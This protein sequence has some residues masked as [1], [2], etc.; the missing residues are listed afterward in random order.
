MK[1]LINTLLLAG[2][3]TTGLSQANND[4]ENLNIYS[5]RIGDGK[6]QSTTRFDCSDSIYVF[7][8]SETPRDHRSTVEARWFNP[9]GDLVKSGERGFEP[10]NGG[11]QYAWDGVDIEAGGDAFSNLLGSMFDPAAGY[12]DA[13]GQWRVDLQV[14]GY[15]MPSVHVEV[16]C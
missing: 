14:D 3:C 2:L 11:G 16:L 15:A 6:V 4:L 12:E 10:M 5:A 9:S 7:I 8:Q 1:P 13:I